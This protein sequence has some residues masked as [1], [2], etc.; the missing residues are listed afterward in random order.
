[1]KAISLLS[2]V[3]ILASCKSDGADHEGGNNIFPQIV[4]DPGTIEGEKQQKPGE[5]KTTIK[6]KPAEPSDSMSKVIAA[7]TGPP[8]AIPMDQIEI[9]PK[10]GAV[11]GK[12]GFV[13]NPWTQKEVDVRG[14]KPKSFFRDPNAPDPRHEFIIP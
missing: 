6:R 12:P 9:I 7:N 11:P 8:K 4:T 13:I 2:T 10:A 5:V 3:L 14:M 1:M